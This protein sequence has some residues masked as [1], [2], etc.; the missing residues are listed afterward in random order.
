MAT[1]YVRLGA[2]GNGTGPA[3]NQAWGTITQAVAA[4]SGV[5]GGDT[6]WIAPGVYRETPTFGFANP[7]ST[8]NFFG[9]P[10]ASQFP[11]VSPA[12]IR[13]TGYTSSDNSIAG[14]GLSFTNTRDYLYFRDIS[15]VCSMSLTGSNLTMYRCFFE[16]ANV[17]IGPAATSN[18]NITIDS[19]TS[20]GHFGFTFTFLKAGAN[21][22]PN[23]LVKNCLIVV[24]N[25]DLIGLNFVTGGTGS[26]WITDALVT[27]CTLLGGSRCL[28]V[29]FSSGL[30]GRAVLLQNSI[31]NAYAFVLVSDVTGQIQ[32]QNCRITGSIAGPT[33][34]SGN[35]T[36]MS[37]MGLDFGQSKLGGIPNPQL[38]SNEVGSVNIGW[39]TTSNAPTVDLYGN[40]WTTSIPDAGCG[41]Y[42]STGST[43]FYYPTE[44][45]QAT[46]S[47]SSGSTSQSVELY[48]G[49]TG[50]TATTSGL[51]ARYNKNRTADVAIPLVTRT[52]TQPWVSG[53]FAEV[54]PVTMPGVYRLDIPNE[55][56]SSGYVNTTIVV[57]G[58]SGTNGA[59][60]TIQEP[61]AVGTQLRMGPFT[62]QADG[63]L[64][65][66]RL[67]LIQGSV[68][69]IDFKMVDAYGTGVDGTGTVVT[70]KVYNA[71]GFLIDTYTCTAMYALDGRY[72]F[73]IDSTVT[74]NVGM[75]TINIYRQIGTET[76]VFGRM[77]L[78]VLSP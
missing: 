42:A 31:C 44:R 39:G 15:F 16:G 12:P 20:I 25:R 38:L 75:Y 60:I 74:D 33:G 1:W 47:I 26:G 19:C 9:N 50:L 28:A 7:T 3:L 36:A 8:V 77:K 17:N 54:N 41:A 23:V 27:N 22:N 21:Y 4:G 35:T 61:Q 13:I 58:A 18:A 45:N 63:I 67:K 48:L 49:A 62:V 78:E 11:G 69:S 52:I 65:D 76:N 6:V 34:I 57:R 71:A 66:D 29:G 64:T 14:T 32:Y 10:T 37:Y 59:V 43:S 51:S 56:I 46:I 30:T 73:A 55:A 72:S 53:G 40:T 24:L 70:A 2:T 68:H 5:T